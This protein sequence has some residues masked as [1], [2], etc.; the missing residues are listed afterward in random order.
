MRL[1]LLLPC[2]AVALLAAAGMTIW[3]GCDVG[4]ATENI[5]IDPSDVTLEKGQSQVFTVSGGYDY[6]WA[7][8]DDASGS[9]NTRQGDTVTFTLLKDTSSGTSNT[10]AGNITVSCTSFIPGAPQGSN[11]TNSQSGGYNETATA[12]VH[13]LDALT[14]SPGSASIAA[15][16]SMGLVASGGS[17]SYVWSVSG[18]GSLSSTSGGSVTFVAGS[19]AGTAIIT[20][21][22]S[23]GLTASCTVTVLASG[24]TSTLTIAAS[25]TAFP[26]SIGTA[27]LSA[28]GGSGSY[29]SWTIQKNSGA[30]VTG[31]PISPT[32]GSPVTFTAPG[33]PFN[34]TITVTDSASGTASITL[35]GT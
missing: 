22:D 25:Q 10:S 19:T 4:S 3:S 12:L 8:S 20:V 13:I 27:A 14:L 31:T 23:D 17:G 26:G 11:G 30:T 28:S 29:T 32:S 2:L 33:A 5:Q 6:T 7:L 34:W 35:S 18:V 1:K 15:G 9:L 16:S 24:G 21:T